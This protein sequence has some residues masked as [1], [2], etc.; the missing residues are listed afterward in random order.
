MPRA[1]VQ[2]LQDLLGPPGVALRLF[3]TPFLS[4]G[5]G[6]WLIAADETGIVRCA[7]L[8]DAEAEEVRKLI[9]PRC[10][11]R[12][13]EA[14]ADRA[15]E[16][17]RAWFNEELDNLTEEEIPFSG[18]LEG[19]DYA[20]RCWRAAR[21]APP[22]AFVSYG[23]VARRAG[24]PGAVRSAGSAMRQNPVLILTPCHRVVPAQALNSRPIKSCGGF[25]GAKDG[26][27]V[28]L[29][30]ALL[31]WEAARFP[32]PDFQRMGRPLTVF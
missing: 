5:A 8:L 2:T 13:A 25:A 10:G 18:R 1:K 28:A 29:K 23:E 20:K 21:A 4:C 30:R 9:A 14:M 11:G 7:S 31:A 32:D 17:Y 27:K 6:R 16:A 19:P 3:E 12:A 24:M 15:A 22:G 26:P